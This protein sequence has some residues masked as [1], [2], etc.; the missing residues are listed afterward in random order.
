MQW[1]VACHRF[2]DRTWRW[3]ST[4][5]LAVQPA[6]P[7]D[8]ERKWLNNW[9]MTHP[10][11]IYPVIL[12]FFWSLFEM[13]HVLGRYSISRIWLAKKMEE[14]LISF[15]SLIPLCTGFLYIPLSV[16]TDFCEGN[17]SVGNS[18]AF[19][20]RK[21]CDWDWYSKWSTGTTWLI[22]TKQPN[23]HFSQY[24]LRIHVRVVLNS[25]MWKTPS[26]PE[27]NFLSPNFSE[28]H[29]YL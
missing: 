19:M 28:P 25:F 26:S 17:K 6:V 16:I 9:E 13:P 4:F 27:K 5:H 12:W 15:R 10:I 3:S 2:L 23:S 20:D 21:D 18:G 14:N 11:I 7:I 29:V 1:T 22:K 8:S 24:V